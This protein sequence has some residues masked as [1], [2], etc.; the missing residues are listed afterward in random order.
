[1]TTRPWRDSLRDVGAAVGQTAVAAQRIADADARIEAAPSTLTAEQLATEISV[2]RCFGDSCRYL[3][4]GTSFSGQV[5]DE[6]GVARPELQAS[7]AKARTFVEVSPE[8]VDLLD[9]DPRR[10]VRR[11]RHRGDPRRWLTGRGSL[12][13]TPRSESAGRHVVSTAGPTTRRAAAATAGSVSLNSMPIPSDST[14]GSVRSAIGSRRRNRR[15]RPRCSESV[16]VRSFRF[17]P[18]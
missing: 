17:R 12:R 7:D 14:S 11:R 5:L 15:P 4:G 16:S 2:I 10:G 18:P 8:R 6:L 13:C 1:M 9:G 3:P